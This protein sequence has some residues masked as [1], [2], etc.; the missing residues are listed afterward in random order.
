MLRVIILATLSFLF[1]KCEK[2]ENL[3]LAQLMYGPWKDAPKG[4]SH[5]FRE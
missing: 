3:N 1:C 2:I 5:S 4:H